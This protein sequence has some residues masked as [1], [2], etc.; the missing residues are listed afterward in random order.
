MSRRLNTVAISRQLGSGG[1]Q[2][3][4]LVAERLGLRYIDR[5]LLRQ[6]AEYVHANSQ[7]TS[8]IESSLSWFDRLVQTF[9]I[10]GAEL[11]Y[12][13]PSTD[14]MYE[15]DVFD[16]E[17]RLM[18]EIADAEEA[19]MVGRGAAQTLRGRPGVVTVFL[20]APEAWRIERL[21]HIY[22]LADRRHAEQLIR[23]SDRERARF[24]RALN[25]CDWT[26]AR[27]YDLAIDTSSVGI[28]GAV[29]AIVRLCSGTV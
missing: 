14:T 12:V 5:E 29:D 6:A 21:Q 19:V 3:G 24:L 22:S 2:V 20:H 25:N 7:R 16:A 9:A 27:M 4:H 15:G 1:A 13:P 23:K 28:D 17:R 11:G 10:G 18:M 8:E 26:D